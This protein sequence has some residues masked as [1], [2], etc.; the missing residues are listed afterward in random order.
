MFCLTISKILELFS[1]FP[2]VLALGDCEKKHY[3][4]LE[5]RWGGIDVSMVR[6][7][8]VNERVSKR[9]FL[10]PYLDSLSLV[11]ELLVRAPGDPLAVVLSA[12]I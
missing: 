7:L 12:L 8:R 1:R 10:L 5:H 2:Y 4:H 11:F 3:L 9:L 6:H